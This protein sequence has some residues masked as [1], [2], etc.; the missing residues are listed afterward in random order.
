LTV[1]FIL[2][3]EELF[4]RCFYLR[5]KGA[6]VLSE[7]LLAVTEVVIS[8]ILIVLTIQLVFQQQSSVTVQSAYEAVARDVSTSIDRA[9]AAAGAIYIE[10]PIPKGLK[11]NLTIDYK[12]VLVSYG[13][14]SVR[15]SFVGLTYTNPVT[16]SNPTDLC[17]VKTENDRKVYVLQGNCTCDIGSNVCNPVCSAKGICQKSCVTSNPDDVCNSVC[18]AN[19][20]AQGI[21]DPDCYRNAT[22]K[23]FNPYCV[24]PNNNPDG[25]CDPDSNNI[26][27]G[28]CDKDCYNIYSNGKTGVCDPDCPSS[29]QVFTGQNGT[30]YKTSDGQC[31]TGCINKTAAT[32]IATANQTQKSKITLISDGVCDLDCNS[33]A[34]ICDPDCPNS[35]ACQNICMKEGQAANGQP[36]CS[37]LTRCPGTDICSKSCCGNGK[38]EDSSMW[39][40]ANKTLWE[41]KYTCPQ[42]CGNA[43]RPAC[44][45]GGPFVSSVC[46]SD[47]RN[48]DGSRLGDKPA[49]TGTAISV[50]DSQA[51]LYLD[52]RS[53]DINA[54]FASIT[55][56]P[57]SGFAF[58]GS[59]YINACQRIQPSGYTISANENFT[60]SSP[61]CCSIDG[62]GCPF[63]DAPY[64]GQQCAGVGYCADHAAAMLS[65]LRTL[66]IPPQDVFITF[67]ISGAN[68]GRHAFVAMKCDPNLKSNSALWPNA[69]NGNEGQWLGVDATNHF[70]TP[71]KNYPC[72]SLGIFW[73]D[74]GIYPLTYGSAAYFPNLAVPAGQTPQGYVIP[75][76]AVCNTYNQ[77][78]PQQCANDFSVQHSY[79]ELCKPFNVNCIVPSG[80]P[81]AV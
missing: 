30:K 44:Q 65:I 73:N 57:P 45:P 4:L 28:I 12:T 27:K 80:L 6:V 33:T 1:A 56:S 49:W 32:V 26:H 54:V 67:E 52:R 7:T 61:I 24:N 21:C 51:E 43:T 69:C 39:P 70:V 11:L 17:V 77:P 55:K 10:Q 18:L 20:L 2:C 59:R 81:Q 29:D 72:S 79:Q 53:W 9:A 34:S 50:C 47:I 36:C 64:L 71:L 37:G 15:K 41:T 66:G 58:D 14:Q 22:D 62:T 68:C 38:C 74:R 63:P 78:T 42:D 13:S 31:Y 8:F 5:E 19:D 46:Y 75:P 25:V 23:V 76:D 40:P 60:S 3:L 16:I 35:L 48:Q